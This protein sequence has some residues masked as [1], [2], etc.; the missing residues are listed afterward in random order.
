[1]NSNN[2]KILTVDDEKEACGYMASYLRRRGHAALIANSAG[3]ALSIVKTQS[4]D[5]M[6]LDINLPG[7]SGTDLLK[8]VR[9]FNSDIK[10]VIISG[11]SI[12][13]QYDPEFKE[14]GV[15]EFIEK[16]MSFS[17]LDSALEKITKEEKNGHTQINS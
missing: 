11:Y 13:L 8:L 2:L 15:S 16:P 1:M 4:P 17:T 3:E 5:V 14:L 7:M 9:Q 6:L 10:V 12:N